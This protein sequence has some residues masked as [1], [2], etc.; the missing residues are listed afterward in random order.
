MSRLEK[1]FWGI[2]ALCVSV[3]SFWTVTLPEDE[4]RQLWNDHDPFWCSVGG[5]VLIAICLVWLYRTTAA[6]EDR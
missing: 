6:R 3:F 2:L 4:G 5:S 1:I